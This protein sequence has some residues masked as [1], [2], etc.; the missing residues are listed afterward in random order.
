M[1]Q[2][3]GTAHVQAQRQDH[4]VLK[5]CAWTLDLPSFI[6]PQAWCQALGDSILELKVPWLRHGGC[7]FSPQPCPDLCYWPWCP[8][9]EDVPGGFCA[10]WRQASQYL[11]CLGLCHLPLALWASLS[12]TACLLTA[13]LFLSPR[14]S[15]SSV[16]GHHCYRWIGHQPFSRKHF[17]LVFDSA[18]LSFY[19]L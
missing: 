7:D 6:F 17:F 19:L 11:G 18:S 1:C 9:E 16:R 15:R 4:S 5:A 3:E 12:V 14:P 8:E 10:C 2:V 13:S